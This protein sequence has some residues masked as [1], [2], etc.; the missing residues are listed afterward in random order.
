MTKIFVQDIVPAG[1]RSIRNIPLPTSKSMP[2]APKEVVE[3]DVVAEEIEQPTRKGS[4]SVKPPKTP[5]TKSGFPGF[6]VWA[7][8]V[9]ALLV[10]IYAGSFLFVTATATIVPKEANVPITVNGKATSQDSM[11]TDATGLHFTIATLTREGSK[12]VPAGT[13]EK[14]EKK[15][16]GKIIIYN[17]YSA[18]PQTLV[19]NT[20]FE[21]AS[22]LI[23]RIPAQVVVPGQ[24]TV[25]GVVTPGSVE[26]SVNAD[27]AGEKYNIGLGDFTIPGFKGD[28]RFAKFSAK[29]DPKAPIA[30]GF[31]GVA[32]K[33]TAND[34]AAAKVAI[35]T[36]LKNELQSALNSQIPDTHVLFGGASTFDFDELPQEAGEASG[37]ATIKEKGTVYGIL[38]DKNELSKYLAM[39]SS[40]I[41][42][43]D[44]TVE[45]I[46]S[47]HFTLDN[48]AG[49]NPASTKD[50]TFKLDGT[51]DFVWNVNKDDVAKSLTGEKRGNIRGILANFESV[52]RASVSIHPIW[53][54]SM[55]KNADKIRVEI[56]ETQ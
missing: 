52:D 19:A 26:V 38:F 3:K 44:V 15:A 10:V 32:R 9:V 6:G 4:K 8:I 20:R 47:L 53:I 43:K 40:E 49:F 33:V 46:D 12:E 1:K 55:P 24:K 56:E 18:D 22:G 23:F 5:K 27:A 17:S 11:S 50:I 36:Q 14:V 28:P 13:E 51:A 37:T 7:T 31:V 54:F 16:T 48:M 25:N 21:T 34:T 42:E 30:G 35:E 45:N 29:S 41:G 2:M 39:Q